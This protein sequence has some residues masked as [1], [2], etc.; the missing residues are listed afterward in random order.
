MLIVILLS[1]CTFNVSFMYAA[2]CFITV[3]AGV[4]PAVMAGA[5]PII[6]AGAAPTAAS[7]LATIMMALVVA[8]G[9]FKLCR[10]MFLF[11]VKLS[12]SLSFI[13]RSFW[14]VFFWHQLP[15]MD[16]RDQRMLCSGPYRH[17]GA[18]SPLSFEPRH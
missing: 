15:T 2:Y 12:N 13:V 16:T 17:G 14:G 18:C 10:L 4:A 1:D 9:R 11:C 6:A 7:G 8:M 3:M 5:G